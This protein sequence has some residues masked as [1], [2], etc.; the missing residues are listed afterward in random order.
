VTAETPLSGPPEQ[1]A[2]VTPGVTPGVTPAV[3][4]AAEAQL[5]DIPIGV[6]PVTPGTPE[7][8]EIPI[9]VNPITPPGAPGLGDAP[10]PVGPPVS[11]PT[12][13][14]IDGSTVC[15][16]MSDMCD[17]E[18]AEG[19]APFCPVTSPFTKARCEGGC[20]FSSGK[21]R[22]PLCKLNGLG[23]GEPA[24]VH[25]GGLHYNVWL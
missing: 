18:A 11:P 7:I 14:P 15:P 10:S 12:G 16:P 19:T 13:V 23:A 3:T 6:N 24:V 8:P 21:C 1:P 22:M 2:L 5:P 20:C 9:G 25:A 4:P 17:E